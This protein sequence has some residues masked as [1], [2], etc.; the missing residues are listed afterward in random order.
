MRA[1]EPNAI[2]PAVRERLRVREVPCR[3]GVVSRAKRVQVVLHITKDNLAEVV[4]R[5]GGDRLNFFRSQDGR[6]GFFFIAVA[7]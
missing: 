6:R 4:Q 3:R 7:F 1:V 2:M 5:L